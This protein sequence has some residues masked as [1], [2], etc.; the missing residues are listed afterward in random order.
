MGTRIAREARRRRLTCRGLTRLGSARR[1]PV[2]DRRHVPPAETSG[3]FRETLPPCDR[4]E[5][6]DSGPWHA[7]CSTPVRP[8]PQKV[9]RTHDRIPRRV[10]GTC[11]PPLRGI[12]LGPARAHARV[13]VSRRGSSVARVRVEGP[14]SAPLG[15][16]A[17]VVAP[18][19]SDGSMMHARRKKEPLASGALCR[20][21]AHAREPRGACGRSGLSVV[22]HEVQPGRHSSR[23]RAL[24][25]TH[26]NMGN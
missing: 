9:S 4:L 6:R 13:A 12:A 22:P 26:Q 1:A 23:Q 18:D 15:R 7:R 16:A 20:A 14:G 24:C 8:S 5:M 11:S 2:R 19:A 3:R 17:V 10:P 21:R 25:N